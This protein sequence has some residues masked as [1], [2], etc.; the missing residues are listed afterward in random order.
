MLKQIFAGSTIATLLLIGG[1][2]TANAQQAPQQAP[3]QQ[4]SQVDVD[5]ADLQRFATTMKQLQGIQKQAQEAM[6]QAVEEQ[7][8]TVERFN[9]IAQSRQNLEQAPVDVSA[10]EAQTFQNAIAQIG[11]I[12]DEAQGSMETAVQQEGLDV[13]KFNGIAQAIQTNPELQ[14]KVI[15]MIQQ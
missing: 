1:I 4:A 10:E 5:D 15:Q 7:G 8:L 3:M 6:V 11:Q 2:S 14:Q 13:E 12:R 9:E